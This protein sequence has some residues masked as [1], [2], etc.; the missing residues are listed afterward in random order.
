MVNTFG[1][2]NGGRIVG[3]YTGVSPAAYAYNEDGSAI[4]VVKAVF[5]LLDKDAK[6]TT[7]NCL[8]DTIALCDETETQPYSQYYLVR[9]RNVIEENLSLAN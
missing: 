6:E 7:V 9:G 4:T 2:N 8:I 1:D 5:K 3:N